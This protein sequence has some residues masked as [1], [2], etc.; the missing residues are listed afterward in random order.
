MFFR[1][2]IMVKKILIF[3]L[4]LLSVGSVEKLVGMQMALA[5]AHNKKEAGYYN[6]LR[7][8]SDC[9][10]AIEMCPVSSQE[11]ETGEFNRKR[12]KKNN[13][14]VLDAHN[15]ASVGVHDDQIF[16]Q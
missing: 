11:L 14:V 4:S 6:R 13:K 3:G 9:E 8:A 2:F 15:V 1:G 12:K 16:D 10:D 5:D 7:N